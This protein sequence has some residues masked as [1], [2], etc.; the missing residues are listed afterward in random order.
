MDGGLET[1]TNFVHSLEET[2]E[3]LGAAFLGRRG[4]QRIRGYVEQ[5]RGQGALGSTLVPAGRVGGL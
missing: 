1:L 2:S 3:H 4:L 5:P